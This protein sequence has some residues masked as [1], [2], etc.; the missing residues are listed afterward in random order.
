VWKAG[1]A[2]RTWWD[3]GASIETPESLNDAIA[4]ATGVSN[5]TALTIPLLLMPSELRGWKVT[6][7]EMPSRIPDA[8]LGRV[9]CFRVSGKAG[10]NSQTVWLDRNSYLLLCIEET[11]PFA[12]FSTEQRTTYEPVVDGDLAEDLLVFGAPRT[13]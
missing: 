7:L 3:I 11:V 2:V 8:R 5:G 12:G 9:E 13:H 6:E 4:G 1:S 10:G